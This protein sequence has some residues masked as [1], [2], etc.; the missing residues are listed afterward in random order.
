MFN[1]LKKHVCKDCG[2]KKAPYIGRKGSLLLEIFLWFM[3]IIPG[4]IYTLWRF[5][6][7]Q[8]TCPKCG[9]TSIVAHDTPMGKKITQQL[10]HETA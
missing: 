6:N 5:S 10:K 3:F 4:I 1:L 8:K 7:F 9:S 2:T